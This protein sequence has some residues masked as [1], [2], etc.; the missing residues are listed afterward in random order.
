MT[1]VK[2]KAYWASV[3]QPNTTF[4]PEWAIDILVDDNNRAAFEADG[5]PIK[6]KDDE[7][8][9]FV[10]IRQRVARR[11]GTQNDAPAVVDAQKQPF[12]GLIGNGSVVNV[13][14][15]PFAWEMNGKSGVSPLLKK[16]QVVDLVEYKAGEDF[17][18]EDGFTAAQAPSANE[19]LNDEVPF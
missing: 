10:H 17:D 19:E 11:D 2:G 5:V 14:Y 8:G 9:D 1:V 6:N 18:V 13:M 15:T 4:E 7:R 12:T 3:Q 16:V